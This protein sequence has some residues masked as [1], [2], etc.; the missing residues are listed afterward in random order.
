MGEIKK[1]DFSL[2]LRRDVKLLGEMLGIVLK[3]HGGIE[4]YETVERIR[5]KSIA[6][7]ASNDED[8]YKDLST[9]MMLFN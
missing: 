4:L 7:I 1:E 9:D 8:L 2:P 3:N 6:L 5:R